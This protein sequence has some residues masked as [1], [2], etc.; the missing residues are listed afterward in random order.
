L[1]EF[2]R[3]QSPES[4]SLWRV[5]EHVTG[6]TYADSVKSILLNP[7][8]MLAT[9][10]GSSFLSGR[11][12]GQAHYY[13]YPG[14]PQRQSVFPPYSLVDSPYGSFD[15]E[16]MDSHGGWVSSP[17]DLLTFINSIF[18]SNF[19]NASTLG[20]IA[21]QRISTDSSGHYYGLGWAMTAAGSGFNFWHN[22]SLP[23]T[24]HEYS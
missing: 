22:G 4:N 8:S 16:N 2:D 15:L 11:R 14:E 12:R 9:F 7:H 19:L 21:T 18:G 24:G 1:T 3:R 5:I 6:Q 10:E 13:P 23:G 20:Q 17:I